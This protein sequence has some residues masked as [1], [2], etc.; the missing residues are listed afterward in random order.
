MTQTASGADARRAVIPMDAPIGAELTGLDVAA[1]LD[2]AA[3]AFVRDALHRHAVIVIRDQHL[4]PAQL[5]TFAKQ[6]G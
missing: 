6:I 5:T 1:G 4:T 2:A 3:L